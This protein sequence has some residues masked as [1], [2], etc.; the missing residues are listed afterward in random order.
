MRNAVKQPEVVALNAHRLAVCK[1][2]L[3][4]L[5]VIQCHREVVRYGGGSHVVNCCDSTPAP[6]WY[7]WFTW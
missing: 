4:F 6:L 1:L 7:C 5:R 3:S 2:R